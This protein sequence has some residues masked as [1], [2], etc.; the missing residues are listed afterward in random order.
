MYSMMA[1]IFDFL[2]ITPETT[3]DLLKKESL[4]KITSYFI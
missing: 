2:E 1:F 3:A 4:N